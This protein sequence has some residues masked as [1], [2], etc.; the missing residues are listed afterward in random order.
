M[1]RTF[2]VAAAALVALLLVVPGAAAGQSPS[3]SPDALTSQLDAVRRATVQYNW[4]PIAIE[5]GFAPFALDGGT[6]PTCFDNTAGGMGVHYVKGVDATVDP[7]TPEAM[8]YQVTD[9]GET[10]LGAVEYIVP[11]E[12]VED[13]NGNPV[14]LPELFGQKFHKHPTLPLYILHAWIWAQNPNGMFADFNPRV[15]AC[16]K[17]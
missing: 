5:D 7:L 1:Q 15:P 9:Q 11:K 16:M 13:A 14:N 2:S 10:R 3:P 17:M 6:M 8:V 12:D 4:L